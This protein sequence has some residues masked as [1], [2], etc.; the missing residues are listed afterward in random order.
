MIYLVIRHRGLQLNIPVHQALAAEDQTVLE[1]LEERFAHSPAAHFIKREPSAIPITR[2]PQPLELID[3]AVAV[4]LLPFPYALDQ[5]LA[6]DVVAVLVFVFLK[7]FLHHGLRRDAG[8]VE[9]GDPHRIFPLH[10][11]FADKDVLQRVIDGVAQVQRPRHIGGRNDD[12]KR[13]PFGGRVRGKAPL[14]DPRLIR[15]LFDGGRLVSLW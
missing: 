1:Q 3:N 5:R 7:L 14:F 6:P 9:A 11:R 10:P 2:A 13:L 8:M 15:L 12:G 4:L